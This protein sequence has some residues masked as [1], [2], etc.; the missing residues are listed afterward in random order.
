MTLTRANTITSRPFHSKDDFWRVRNLIVET[1]PLTPTS[2]NWDMRRW[3][4]WHTHNATPKQAE[5]LARQIQLWETADGQLVG[6]VHPEGDGECWLEVHPDYRSLEDEMLAWGEANLAIA[7]AGKRQV[8]VFC[9]DYD[10]YRQ[11]LLAARGYQ[12]TP[13]GGVMRRLRFGKRQ[14]P[15][16]QITEGFRL[17]TTRP[18]DDGDCQKMADLLNAA[19]NRTIHSAPEYR[20]FV[21][22]SPSF[23]HDLNLV[24]EAPDGSFAAHVGVNYEPAYFYGIFEPVCT[25]PDHQRKGLARVLMFEGL[26]RLQA[27]GATDAY[28]G[29][30]DGMGSNF[31]YEAVGFTE[32]YHGYVWRKTF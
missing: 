31:L 20:N 15:R 9:N 14:I 8:E 5:T 6:A 4:G 28:V 22:H 25:H 27:I 7:E 30:G 11:R 23:R 3:D 17:R 19:F 29:T 32:V 13:Y 24:A 2:F 1:Y 16:P 12:Q 21:E 18:L 26:C 10:H